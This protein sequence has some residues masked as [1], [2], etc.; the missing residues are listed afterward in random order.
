MNFKIPSGSD[1]VQ[2]SIRID[3]ADFNVIEKLS[4]KSKKSNNYVINSMIKYA[5]S[6]M[7]LKD[8]KNINIPER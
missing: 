2:F 3:E 4:V 5:I 6:N 8:I 1:K 7:D